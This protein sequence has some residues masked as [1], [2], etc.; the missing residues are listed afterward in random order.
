MIPTDEQTHLF[1]A[2]SLCHALKEVN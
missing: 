2:N 1:E